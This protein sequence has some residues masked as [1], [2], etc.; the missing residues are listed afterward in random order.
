MRCIARNECHQATSLYFQNKENLL[1]ECLQVLF[2]Q[3]IFDIERQYKTSDTPEKKLDAI[4]FAGRTF[5][6]KQKELFVI[7]MHCWALSMRNPIMHKKFSDLYEK[8]TG[9]IEQILTEG[10]RKGAF[11]KVAVTRL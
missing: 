3:F 7:F 10:Y 4:F 6:G 9:V 11:H 8:I 5:V 1:K 2:N